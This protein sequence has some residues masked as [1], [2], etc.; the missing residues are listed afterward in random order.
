MN[1]NT[2]VDPAF[3]LAGLVG[4]IEA[5]SLFAYS[6]GLGVASFN[7]SGATSSAPFIEVM[8]YLVFAVGIGL[9]ARGMLIGSS[10]ARP[11]FFLTQIFVLVVAYT[12]FVGDGPTVKAVGAAV[13]ALGLAGLAAGIAGIV[14]ESPSQQ[15]SS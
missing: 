4:G 12:V 3:R 10:V 14:R 8:I 7:S 2:R 6:V 13:A 1:E 15:R 9:A 5:L 11:P